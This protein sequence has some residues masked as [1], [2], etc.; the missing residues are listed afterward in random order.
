M[1]IRWIFYVCK[2]YDGDFDR[3]TL[4]FKVTLLGIANNPSLLIHVLGVFPFVYVLNL[5]QEWVMALSTCFLANTIK[6]IL[7]YLI[8]FNAVIN[9]TFLFIFFY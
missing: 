4:D 8:L 6:W 1:I 2:K 9:D 3:E 7:S 5:F